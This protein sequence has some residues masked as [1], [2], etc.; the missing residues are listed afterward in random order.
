M[1]KTF[2]SLCLVLSLICVM[3]FSTTIV[4]ASEDELTPYQDVLNTLNAQLG[5]H[6]AFPSE[7]DLTASGETY[8][9]VVEFYTAMSMDEFEEFVL[10]AHENEIQGI[11]TKITNK[12]QEDESEIMPLAFSKTQKCYYDTSGVNY[13]SITSTVYHAD[14]K[15]RYSSINSYSKKCGEIPYYL[16]KSMTCKKSSDSTTVDCRFS[17]SKYIAPNLTDATTHVLEITFRASDGD[18][19]KTEWV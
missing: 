17:C 2:T 6:Y 16:P 15:D 3:L 12:S 8:N 4:E 13:I 11:Y 14:G 10:S 18:M 19:H 7:D 1:R 9:D 5:T